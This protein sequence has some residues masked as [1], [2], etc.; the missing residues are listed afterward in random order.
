MVREDQDLGALA[1]ESLRLGAQLAHCRLQALG[2][3]AD[4][5]DRGDV[6]RRLRGLHRVQLRCVEHGCP[7]AY[8]KSECPPSPSGQ[9]KSANHLG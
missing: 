9:T 6:L 1:H 8:G 5:V 2:P 3:T 7:A 4:R